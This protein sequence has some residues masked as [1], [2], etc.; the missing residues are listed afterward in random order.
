MRRPRALYWTPALRNGTLCGSLSGDQVKPSLIDEVAE[1][2]AGDPTYVLLVVEE[3]ALQLHKRALEYRGLNGDF[4][5][6]ALGH[7]IGP[8]AFYHILGFI[9]YFVANYSSWEPGVAS[10]YLNR[11]GGPGR[12]S[13]YRHQMSGWDPVRRED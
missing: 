6:E 11:L 1:Q 12:W 2:V 9:E 5:G 8:Q 3:F 13:A 7:E 4:I 10:E